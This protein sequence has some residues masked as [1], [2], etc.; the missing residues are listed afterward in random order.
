MQKP[1]S[2]TGL[3]GDRRNEPPGGLHGF[4]LILRCATQRQ[5]H[6]P[7]S[8]T[9][10]THPLSALLCPRLRAQTSG[11]TAKVRKIAIRWSVGLSVCL[12]PAW[13]SPGATR[14]SIPSPLSYVTDAWLCLES[15]K[16]TLLAPLRKSRLAVV[17][18]AELA[19]QGARFSPLPR[20]RSLRKLRISAWMY[21]HLPD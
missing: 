11:R 21:S 6:T 1:A 15:C 7:T 3:K 18:L 9:A 2:G 20:H 12:P 13:R 10:A 19:P 16:R 14:S 8:H 4:R 17:E 5:P